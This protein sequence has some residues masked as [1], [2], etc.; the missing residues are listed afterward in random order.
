[1]AKRLQTARTLLSLLIGAIGGP[2]MATAAQLSLVQ[3]PA[4][5]AARQPVP[6]VILTLDDSGSMA[7]DKEGFFLLG[8]ERNPASGMYALKAALQKVFSATEQNVPDGA[9]RLAWNAMNRCYKI[10][11]ADGG[12]KSLNG[13]RP[14]DATHRANFLN[15]VGTAG[16]AV[17]MS[18]RLTASG[19]TPTHRAYMAA[20][21]YLRNTPI[22]D[23]NGP[24]ANRPGVEVGSPQLSCR[25]SYNILMTDGGWNWT[26]DAHE[27][28]KDVARGP[29]GA[30]GDADGVTQTLPD[31]EVY[32]VTSNETKVYRQT[33]RNSIRYNN[34]STYYDV[35]TLADLAFYYW[36]TDLTTLT[37][38]LK[39]LVKHIGPQTFGTGTSAVTL[40]EYWSPKNNPATWQSMTTYTIGFRDAATWP[41]TGNS[42]RTYPTWAATNDT[43]GG[44]FP[45]LV[46]GAKTWPDPVQGTLSLTTTTEE[47]RKVELW[48]MAIN[49]RGRFIPTQ[50][51]EDLVEAFK[52]IFGTI[53]NDVQTPVTGFTNS[54]SSINRTDVTQYEGGY[55]VD[56]WKGF[57]KAS[58]LAKGSGAATPDPGWGST[59][60]TTADKLDALTAADIPN[61]LILSYRDKATGGGPTAFEWASDETYLSTAQKTLLKAEGTGTVTDTVGQQRLNYLRGDRSLESTATVTAQFRKRGS[62]QGD[63]V[64]STI[65]YVAQPVSNYAFSGYL[66]FAKK[67]AKRLPMLYVG[68]NDGMLHG[69]SGIDG[70]EKI[71]YVPKGVIQNLP[72]LTKA[73]YVHRYFV[74]GSPFSGDVFVP[75]TPSADP[76]W[77]T[78]LVGTLGAGGKGY[79]VLDVTTPG[80]T[81]TGSTAVA[82]NFLKANASA[83]V[84]MDKTAHPTPSVAI[85][86]GT[87]SDDIG[88]IMAKP[89]LE[90]DNPQKAT[91]IVRMNNGR[92]AVVMGNGVNSTNERPVL[93][94]QYLDGSKELLRIPA[95]TTGAN[96]TGN[97]LSA[98]RLVDINGDGTPDV[99]YAGDLKGN[100]WKFNV[101]SATSSGWDVAAWGDPGV[102]GPLYS[103]V[104]AT[105]NVSAPQPITVAPLVRPNE[106]GVGGLMVAFGT[107]RN[108]TE[109]DR[110]DTA[111]QSIYSV[112]DNTRYK[113]ASGKVVEDRAAAIPTAVGTG[114]D[115]LQQQTVGATAIDGQ[116]QS[117]ARDF[118]TVSQNSVSYQGTGAK[119]GWY[120]NL[121]QSGER[122]LD[123]MAFFDSSNIIEVISEAP[124]SGSS[125][126][127]ESCAP[128]P[129]QQKTFRT[130]LNIM[131]GKKPS[132][133]VMDRN[134]DGVYDVSADDG[135]SRMTASTTENPLRTKGLEIRKGADGIV[136]N[137]R[138]MPELPLRPSWRQLQ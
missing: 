138:R 118:W 19:S 65:W 134:G 88:H 67:H 122:V 109:G 105:G 30:N 7:T 1:M 73:D 53:V 38:D 16:Q 116:A 87:E 84:V 69:F 78:F 6:N 137:L 40:S 129:T 120:L 23:R 131:D 123:Q 34:T 64:N 76:E 121:P 108:L 22:T 57:V 107:G 36:A 95:A 4:G 89:V 130:L 79:F 9:I 61:R 77:R 56:G 72:A 44:S 86:A 20:G 125:T 35:S 85:T 10:P 50:E 132:V 55:T 110:T 47:A 93:L 119:K 102:K 60:P 31:G 113:L 25:R 42:F 128:P 99:V 8:E 21:D 106:R 90:D 94:I 39:P 24:W 114:V 33:Q 70:S 37:N 11:D 112:L 71:A 117:A 126:A 48:H 83:L 28:D 3:Y 127:E 18:K 5:S 32:S 45:E 54:S 63:I 66:A 43:Y 74:D 98:P 124:A 133:Q 82:S 115:N 91:Q 111:V 100:L 68:G 15:W 97:G 75:P 81:V 51:S 80:S 27:T 104:Y 92:W 96:A 103:A 12:C 49:S 2:Q 101:S 58:T 52:E 136:D 41:T 13:M 29:V 59:T 17:D 14:L 46:T 135:V 62:R 26:F